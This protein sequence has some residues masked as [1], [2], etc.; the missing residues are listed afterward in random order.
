MMRRSTKAENVDAAPVKTEET[1]N[2]CAAT[3]SS[4]RRPRRSLNAL[5]I[6]DPSRQPTRAQLLAQPISCGDVSSK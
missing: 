1:A 3:T 6:M 5:Q 4:L 2:S